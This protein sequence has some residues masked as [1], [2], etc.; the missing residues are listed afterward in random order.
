[1]SG[2]LLELRFPAAAEHLKGVREAVKEKIADSGLGPACVDDVVLAVDE[3]LQNVIRHAYADT[4]GGE[5]LL[6]LERE[7]AELV[8]TLIDFAPK[9]D[10]STV[11]PRALDE[12]R[13]GGLG[14]HL[15]GEL[16]DS[17]EFGEAPPGCGNLLRLRKRIG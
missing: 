14:T 7:D 16:M 10:P 3:A 9:I 2:P 11:R 12:V 5:I 13:P 8:F 6:R 1:M 4:P 15:I 17:A